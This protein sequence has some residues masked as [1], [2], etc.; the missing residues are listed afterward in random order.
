[1]LKFQEKYFF[2]IPFCLINVKYSEQDTMLQSIYIPI[3]D[4]IVDTKY[5]V[6]LPKTF[7]N[8]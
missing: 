7:L 1:M 8:L 3:T 4:L 6:N 2:A 5:N